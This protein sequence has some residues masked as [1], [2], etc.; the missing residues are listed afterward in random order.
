[1]EVTVT[2]LRANL[3]DCV[4]RARAGEDVVVT[5]RGIPVAR[6]VPVDGTDVIERLTREGVLSPARSAPRRKA[7]RSPIRPT[8]GPPLSDLI[9]ELRR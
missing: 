7:E 2:Q 9:G 3:R 1:M 5:E 6:L 4:A 8:P